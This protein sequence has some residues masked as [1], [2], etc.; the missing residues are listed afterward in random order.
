MRPLM[1]LLPMLLLSMLMLA[2][3]APSFAKKERKIVLLRRIHTY[4][5]TIDTTVDSSREAFSYSRS[6]INVERRNSLLMTVPSFS[7][8]SS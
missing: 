3:A 6:V 8:V 7:T 1:R 2:P 4:A 5:A